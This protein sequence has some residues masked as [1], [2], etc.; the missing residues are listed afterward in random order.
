MK[1]S[2]PED[3]TRADVPN[4]D[5]GGALGRGLR[6]L[7]A[8]NDL[9]TATISALVTETGL[10]KPTTIRLLKTLVAEGYAFHEPET[11]TYSVTAKVS[12]L[13]RALIGRNQVDEA[14]KAE[15]DGLADTLKWPV[16]FMVPEGDSMVIRLSNRDRAPIRL[17]LFERR[18]FPLLK[19]ASGLAHLADLSPENRDAKLMRSG[20]SAADAKALQDEIEAVAA[21]GYA[22]RQFPELAANMRVLSVAVPHAIGALSLVHFDDVVTAS[23]MNDHLVPA[24]KAAAL[25]ASEH[26]EQYQR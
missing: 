20:L 3:I 12:S 25:R 13:S 19:S 15:L 22:V 5:T 11:Q 2:L 1:V 9:E 16:E 26:I 4:R 23:I 10:A 17:R 24:L 14:I 8:L 6:L 7:T 21:Q 18:R